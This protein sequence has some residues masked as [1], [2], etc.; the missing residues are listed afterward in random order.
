MDKRDYYEVLGISRDASDDEL[1]RA[2]KQAALK[3]HPDR[4]QGDAAA[5]RK[6]KEATEAYAILNDKE[7][8]AIYDRFGH[9]GLEGRGG[10]HF[11][12]AGGGGVLNQIQDL[13]S[14]LLAA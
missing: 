6:F 9:A 14:A 7:K 3:H 12:G 10:F 1:R 5:E 2:Y 13:V 11:Q 8:R 4:N